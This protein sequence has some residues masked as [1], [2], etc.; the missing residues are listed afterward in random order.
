MLTLRALP[1]FAVLVLS[2]ALAACALNP[3]AV[4]NTPEQKYDA[5][6]LTYDAVLE[7]ALQ[8][9]EDPRAPLELRRS[10]QAAIAQSG[11]VYASAQSAFANFKAAKAAVAAGGPGGQLDAAT[12][13][14]GMW[15]QQ[16]ADVLANL[17]TLT[18]R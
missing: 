18:N 7:P 13:N 17:K 4:A 3:I 5:T 1:S 6:L 16:L 12:E 9:L 10:I 8:L 11:Q 14:L 15:T 2:L